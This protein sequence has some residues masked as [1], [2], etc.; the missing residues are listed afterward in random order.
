MFGRAVTFVAPTSI[1]LEGVNETLY[2][3]RDRRNRRRQQR[4]SLMN[5]NCLLILFVLSTAGL[6]QNIALSFDDGL[7]PE[8]T[9]NAVI[10][11]TLILEALDEANVQSILFA[12]GNRV[13]NPAGLELVKAWG[14]GGHFI[15][16][17][18][19]SHINFAS[20]K[21]TLEAFIEDVAKNEVLLEN[22]P[23]WKKLFRFPYLKEG[24][25]KEKRDAFR[26]W[27]SDHG[28]KVGAV[29]VDASDW[30]YSQRY[31]SWREE[32]PE[33][34]LAVFR[35]AYLDHL[36]ER[37]AYYDSLSRNLLGRSVK[38]VLLLHVNAINAEFL[39]DIIRMYQTKGWNVIDFKDAITDP[40]YSLL[41]DTLPAGESIIWSLAK[42]KGV[43]DLRYPAEDGTYEKLILDNLGL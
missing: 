3:T 13:D 5:T 26:A 10:W 4:K 41:P 34:D 19:Y 16:N 9:A 24:K 7:N 36:W 31:L 11:N 28:Y 21:V 27:L 37:S 20:D 14:I 38:H 6:A 25:T 2:C 29:S 43:S 35:T 15:G 12:A 39:P 40:L 1:Y 30:Y 32:H 17:H 18:T 8:V 42:E 33:E 23:N 22:M